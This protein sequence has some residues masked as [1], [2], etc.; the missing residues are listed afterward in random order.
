L[1]KELSNYK[2]KE[3]QPLEGYLS[4]IN[5]RVASLKTVDVTMKMKKSS[6]RYS[7]NSSNNTNHSLTT[8][9]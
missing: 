2:Y 8:T 3:G 9:K 1:R 4:G 6:Q 5:L 7:V